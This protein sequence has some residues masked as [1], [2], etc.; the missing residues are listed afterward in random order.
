[1]G[2]FVVSICLNLFNKIVTYIRQYPY[3]NSSLV[4]DIGFYSLIFTPVNEALGD[5]RNVMHVLLWM[6]K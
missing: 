6:N 3:L 5:Y 1:M 2:C 4:T